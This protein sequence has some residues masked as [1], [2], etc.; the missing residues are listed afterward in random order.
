MAL[1]LTKD[2]IKNIKAENLELL[3]DGSIK[4]IKK[5]KKKYLIVNLKRL[6]N[7]HNCTQYDF[8]DIIE[9]YE[10]MGWHYMAT[11]LPYI[12]FYKKKKIFNIF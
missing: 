10:K 4:I 8:L 1:K 5:F 7:I 9:Q 3:P 11:L 12:Y 6:Y 2:E